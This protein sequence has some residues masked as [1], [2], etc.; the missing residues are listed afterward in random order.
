MTAS[1]FHTFPDATRAPEK[2]WGDLATETSDPNPNLVRA[3]Q[4]PGQPCGILG[5]TL[6]SKTLS[7]AFVDAYAGALALGEILRGLHGGPRCEAAR[8]QLR[9]N[10]QAQFLMLPDYPYQERLAPGGFCDANPS[11]ASG[12]FTQ[13]AE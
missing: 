4:Q 1:S 11:R 9:S 8:L 3:F 2:I 13:K 6:A 12:G 5:E 7:S 10:S